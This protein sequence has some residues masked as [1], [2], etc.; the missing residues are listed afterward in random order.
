MC[1]T[2]PWRGSC[3]RRFSSTGVSTG[4]PSWA[5]CKVRTPCSPWRPW[6]TFVNSSR[7]TSRET[8]GV[9]LPY[10]TAGIIPC[11]RRRREGRVPSWTRCVACKVMRCVVA[12]SPPLPLPR[13]A[14]KERTDRLLIVDPPNRLRQ[15]GGDGEHGEACTRLH[16][17]QGD[18]VGDDQLL[19]RRA[20]Q[21]LHRRTGQHRMGHRGEHRFR[22]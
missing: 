6:R 22:A 15:E 20:G 16:V 18:R 17:R 12:I 3:C 5:T 10:S 13:D 21:A 8:G 19:N 1:V 4:L 11:R 7:S 14:V 9:F 2:S